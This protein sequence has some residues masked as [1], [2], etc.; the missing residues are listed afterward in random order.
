MLVIGMT[1][2]IGSG[3]STAEKFFRELGVPVFDADDIVH[4]VTRP[5]QPALAQI[6]AQFGPDALCEDGSLDRAYM[7]KIVF[8]DPAKRH[9]LEA[10]LHPL[11]RQTFQRKISETRAPYCV[12][13]IPLL[14][15]AQQQDL[16][17]RILVIDVPEEE[18][19]RRAREREGLSAHDIKRI[20]ATQVDR[21]TRLAA[22]DDTLHNNG[23]LADLR[24]S[25][26]KLHH[27]YLQLGSRTST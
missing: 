25:I 22:A 18:Q 12:L 19:V 15:E 7:R 13:A 23:S 9:Q 10:I 11:V 17:D 4:E 27:F 14:L 6:A 1:G 24:K 20:M 16:V 8:D 26:E 5:G 21:D 3:K 2:G